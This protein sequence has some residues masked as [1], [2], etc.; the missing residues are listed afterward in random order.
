MAYSAVL[1]GQLLNGLTV[2]A[3][4]RI[5]IVQVEFVVTVWWW[6]VVLSVLSV[7]LSLSLS[8]S[9][10]LCHSLSLSPVK[11]VISHYLKVCEWGEVGDLVCVCACV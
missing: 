7:C 3:F 2:K 10:S 11:S 8:L 6:G 5:C 9:L 4:V 1:L